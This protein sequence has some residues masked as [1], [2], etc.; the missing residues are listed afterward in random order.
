VKTSVGKPPGR[1]GA[2]KRQSV[3]ANPEYT[4]PG[5]N[6]PGRYVSLRRRPRPPRTAGG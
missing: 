4:R 6:R 1:P 5:Q 2:H 3:R